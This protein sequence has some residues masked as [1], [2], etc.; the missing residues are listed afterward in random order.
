MQSKNPHMEYEPTVRV[1]RLMSLFRQVYE[2]YCTFC[3]V[4]KFSSSRMATQSER[5]GYEFANRFGVMTPQARVIHN[6]SNEWQIIKDAVE[7]ARNRMHAEGDEMGKN[8]CTELLEALELSRCLLLMGYVHGCPLF[9]NPSACSTQE[10]AQKTAA[11]LGRLLVLDLV[12]RNEDRLPCRQLGWRGNPANLLFTDKLTFVTLENSQQESPEAFPRRNRSTPGSQR[13]RRFYSVDGRTSPDRVSLVSQMSDNSDLLG[14]IAG[15]NS[16]GDYAGLNDCLD[17][18][19]LVAIDSGVPRRPPAGKRNSDQLQYPNLVELILNSASFSSNLLYELSGERI[20]TPTVGETTVHTDSGVGESIDQGKVVQAFRSGFRAALREMQSLHVFLLKLHQKLEILLRTFMQVI[21][22]YMPNDSD[23]KEESGVCESTGTP[24][25]NSHSHVPDREMTP[26]ETHGEGEDVPLDT[27]RT[28]RGVQGR[29]S[30]RS[31]RDGSPDTASPFSRDNWSSKQSKINGDPLR[32]I[33]MTMKLKD[34]SRNGKCQ[35]D[36]ELNKDLESW[37]QSLKAEVIK[38]CQENNFHTGFFEGSDIHSV[39]DSYEL[40]IRLEHLLERMALISQAAATER[41]SRVTN[42][43]YIGGA[44]AAS[45]IHTLQYLGISH[46]LCLC[47]NELGQ[48]DTQYTD[49]FEYRNFAI[50]DTDDANISSLFEAALEYIDSVENNEGKIL[51]HCFEGKS[52]SAT[53]VLAYLMLRKNYTLQEAWTHLK[54]VHRRAQPNDGFMRTLMDLDKRLHGKASMDWRQRKPIAR[55]CP[56]CLKN[57]GISSSSLKLH[58]QKAH[59]RISSGSV[60]S[61]DMKE[62]KHAIESVRRNQ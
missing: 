36:A 7:M 58:L 17:D 61:Y 23:D 32:S 20:G 39:V 38:L 57:V 62:L 13:E 47:P 9:E 15:I 24:Q 50:Y 41:P 53:V 43:L 19:F 33:R 22:K 34:L 14:S 51:V 11:S 35:V 60:D 52:R 49:L 56:I 28:P 16:E 31:V 40:K 29:S 48:F 44:L 46:I 42:S 21:N 18:F 55:T 37:N 45:S 8:T 2:M 12:L 10:A 6:C 25:S 3:T 4:M 30:S 27:A 26:I 59:R 54:R 1:L 5:L